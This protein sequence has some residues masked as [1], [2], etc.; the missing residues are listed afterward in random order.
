MK[1]YEIL[2]RVG[3]VNIYG[4]LGQGFPLFIVLALAVEE[5]DCSYTLQF[6]IN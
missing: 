4:V 5:S 2:V 3:L 1:F 6:F